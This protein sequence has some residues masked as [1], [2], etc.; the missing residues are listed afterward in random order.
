MIGRRELALMRPTAVLI[1][2]AR[3]AI[4]DEDALV[5]ALADGTILGAGLDVL[6]DEPHVPQ[7]L[8]DHPR[9]VLSP[10]VADGTVQTQAAMSVACAEGLLSEWSLRA[11][12]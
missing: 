6:A 4:C 8:I 1:N 10:H 11:A 7:G 5:E 9:V 2:T 12:R 3:G